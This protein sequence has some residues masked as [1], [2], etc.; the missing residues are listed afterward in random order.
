[1][2][3]GGTH[4]LPGQVMSVRT[5]RAL[6]RHGIRDPFHRSHQL[7]EDDIRRSSLILAMEADHLRWM[8]RIHPQGA[9][10]TGSL[11]RVVRDLGR[12][13]GDLDARVAALGLEDLA[14]ED[15]EEVVDPGGGEQPD[16]GA[17]AD[18]ISALVDRLVE[19]L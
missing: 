15:W 9:P 19:L 7:T 11:R 12:T 14:F 3:S 13:A 18:E 2:T 10:L 1:M 5:R 17:A 6:E 8:R 4:V 16:F